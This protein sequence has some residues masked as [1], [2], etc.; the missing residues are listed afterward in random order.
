MSIRSNAM[1]ILGL[2]CYVT[3]FPSNSLAASCS[4]RT[5]NINFGTYDPFD[6]THLDVNGRIQVRCT[7]SGYVDAQL[8]LNPG[9]SGSC[10]TRTMQKPPDTLNYNIFIESTHSSIFCS[11]GGWYWH[12]WGN[13]PWQFNPTTYGRLFS[14]QTTASPGTYSDTITATLTYTSTVSGDVTFN[15]ENMKQ[16]HGQI[17]FGQ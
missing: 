13:A 8:R 6:P 1:I 4:V 9:S 15:N 10:A 7:G 14:L 3:L 2:L 16:A 12:I 11:P 5:G 17:E